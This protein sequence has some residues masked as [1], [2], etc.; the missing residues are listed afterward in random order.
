MAPPLEGGWILS[1]QAPGGVAAPAAG[2]E[3]PADGV[4]APVAGVEAL[5]AGVAA[6]AAGVAASGAGVEATGAGRSVPFSGVGRKFRDSVAPRRVRSIVNDVKG[7]SLFALPPCDSLQDGQAWFTGHVVFG[8]EQ[9]QVT[10]IE[11]PC[12]S[13]ERCGD[14][15]FLHFRLTFKNKSKNLFAEAHCA[16][17]GGDCLR[18]EARCAGN[19]RFEGETIFSDDKFVRGMLKK[20]FPA[21]LRQAERGSEGNLGI[22]VNA[23][24]LCADQ[25]VFFDIEE[26][27]PPEGEEAPKS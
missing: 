16:R 23:G 2:V 4:E 24:A 14:G 8:E 3:A 5:G 22:I 11:E 7:A 9:L 15:G 27:A 25:L 26:K 12:D 1:K 17:T 20:Y 10:G 13:C 18:L 6:P 21:L 19:V